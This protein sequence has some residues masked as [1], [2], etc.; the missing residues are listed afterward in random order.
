MAEKGLPSPGTLTLRRA[1]GAVYDL[2]AH[3]PAKFAVRDGV[4]EIP[5]AYE[6]TD[7]SVFLVTSRPLGALSVRVDGTAVTVET[8]DADVMIPI[9]IT[10]EGLKKPF[11]AAVSGGKWSRSVPGLAGSV[12]VRN[13]ADGRFAELVK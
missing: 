5:V 2:V 8:K 7:G 6:T 1:A 4:T 9:E 3:R 13:L 10:A 11:Y 12:R